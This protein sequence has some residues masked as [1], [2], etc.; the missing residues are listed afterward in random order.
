M[1]M[2]TSGWRL[3]A[4]AVVAEEMMEGIRLILELNRF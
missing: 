2:A 3:V 1:D 4:A